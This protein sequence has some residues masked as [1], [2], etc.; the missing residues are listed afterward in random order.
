MFMVYAQDLS[1]DFDQHQNQGNHRPSLEMSG[2]VS[3]PLTLSTC[4]G[5]STT[6]VMQIGDLFKIAEGELPPHED[7]RCTLSCTCSGSL[8]ALTKPGSDCEHP[9]SCV[10]AGSESGGATPLSGRSAYSSSSGCDL[11]MTMQSMQLHQLMS[12]ARSSASLSRPSSED[13]AL[14]DKL[15][16]PHP[17]ERVKTSE[18]QHLSL[19]QLMQMA[20]TTMQRGS[21]SSA[22]MI[23][24]VEEAQKG[25][26]EDP[27]AAPA[28][29]SAPQDGSGIVASAAAAASGMWREAVEMLQV[30]SSEIAHDMKNPLNGVLALSQNVVAGV[31]GELPQAAVDQINVVRS[32]AYH[33]LNMINMTRDMMKVWGA[34]HH[35][36]ACT[37]GRVCAS[38]DR[39][40]K[41]HAESLVRYLLCV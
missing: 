21:L 17:S 28:A 36:H 8:I 37:V 4:G 6:R 29:A 9:P 32:C 24:M 15:L 16:T 38:H 1:E 30:H 26:Q 27:K 12:L 39:P 40:F 14:E 2:A 18:L 20:K 19:Q 22:A 35:P 11:L 7:F 3:P 41:L 34:L 13:R 31:F 33:L 10:A 23:A 25:A 5:G